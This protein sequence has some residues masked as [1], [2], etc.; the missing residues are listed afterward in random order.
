MIFFSSICEVILQIQGGG[1][2]GDATQAISAKGLLLDANHNHGA[3]TL[4]FHKY[5][6]QIVLVSNGYLLIACLILQ[7]QST[8]PKSTLHKYFLQPQFAVYIS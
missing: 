3:Q 7:V 8:S 6:T 2:E 1:G 4:H 5:F